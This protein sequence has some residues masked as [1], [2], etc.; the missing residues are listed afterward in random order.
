GEIG[1]NVVDVTGPACHCGKHGCVETYISEGALLRLAGC[2]G[3][4]TEAA[5]ALV[6]ANARAQDPDAL[7]AVRRVAESLGRAV[8][9]VVNSFNPQCLVLGGHLS[10]LLDIA[11]PDIERA[12]RE[13]AFVGQARDVYLVPPSFGSDSALLGA[14]E[15]AFAAL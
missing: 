8:A 15:L 14:A 12:L 7:H 1:H 2:A 4:P 13:Y 3:P 5:T 11:R 10:E 6:F 9:S